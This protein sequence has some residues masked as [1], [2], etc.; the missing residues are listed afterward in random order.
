MKTRY[1]L[2]VLAVLLCLTAAGCGQTVVTGWEQLDGGLSYRLA[3][4]TLHTG[5]LDLNG[6]RYYFLP[7]GAMATGWQQ[8][9]G[10]TYYFNSDGNMTTGWLEAGGNRYYLQ[11]NGGLYTGWLNLDSQQY[12]FREDGTMTTGLAE[13]GGEV[14]LFTDDGPLAEGWFSAADQVYYADASGHPSKGWLELDGFRYYFDDSGI[15]VTGWQEISDL[16]YYFRSDG[17]MATGRVTIDGTVRFFAG[18]G[19]EFLLVNPWN[20]V[21]EGYDPEIKIVEQGHSI[22]AEAY[23]ALREMLADCRAAGLS[24]IICSAYRTIGEQEILFNRKVKYYLNKNYS[25]Q[26]AE[27]LAATS[28]A[29]PGTSE[30]QLGLAVDIVD[31]YH[32][33]LDETQAERPTQKWLMENSWRYGFILRYP[34]GSTELT[35]IIYEPWHYR[36]I[37]KEIAADVYASGLCLEAYLDALTL[38]S[39]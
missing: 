20:F 25:Q 21:P 30:H 36:Y 3:D 10:H 37:G 26:E 5:F 19:Q 16:P 35:G 24:P 2:P 9:E 17:S 29:V 14:Y 23:D 33:L 13:I 7:N 38:A 32:Q 28:V 18:N 1:L 31:K 39:G 4:G 6:N 11:Q 12:H 22:A 27:A 15:M 34:V 8:I